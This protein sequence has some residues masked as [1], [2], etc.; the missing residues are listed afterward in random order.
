L[1]LL[2]NGH[3]LR[4]GLFLA[5]AAG[6]IRIQQRMAQQW[7]DCQYEAIPVALCKDDLVCHWRMVN[8]FVT[9]RK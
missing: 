2:R 4:G 6:A 9:P 5:G 7:R 8:I 3:L 1:G